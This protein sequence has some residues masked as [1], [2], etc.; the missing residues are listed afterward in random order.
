MK[1]NEILE[2]VN[3]L[4]CDA[5]QVILDVY[6]SS[7][8][9]VELKDDD[10]PLTRADKCSHEVLVAGLESLNLGPVLSEEGVDLPWGERRGW[11]QYWLIDPLDGTK[12]FIKRNGEF[13][14]NV[15]L[16]KDGRPVLGVVYAPVKQLLYYGAAGLGAFKRVGST[17]AAEPIQVA[18]VPASDENWKIVGSRSHQSEDFAAFV[19]RF[20]SAD[21]V[22]MGSSLKLC[23]VAE[24]SADLY[25]R[26]GLTSEWDTAAAQAVV[27]AAGGQ[28]LN[29]ES[30]SPLLYNT[31]E[32][33]LNP[34]FI[35]C[36]APSSLW[37]N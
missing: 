21:I 31:K 4:A 14:V 36:A 25:P 37:M 33:L 32:S 18:P 28:V 9:D 1:Q 23:L 19:A 2:R 30:R 22:S 17:S 12:E 15:A 26:L 10:S 13:T 34:F 35:V 6:E 8:F 5:G 20:P 27:E 24:G 7:D 29:W 16:I 11:Q 3:Q